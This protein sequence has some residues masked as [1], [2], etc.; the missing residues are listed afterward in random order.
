VVFGWTVA[1]E[2]VAG[3]F[4]GESTA[5]EGCCNMILRMKRDQ[6]VIGEVGGN[7]KD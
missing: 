6:D 4:D 7:E 1:N 5:L 3:S 2:T